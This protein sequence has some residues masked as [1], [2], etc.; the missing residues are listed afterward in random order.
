[1]S[2][3]PVVALARVLAL[4]L[5][6]SFGGVV[7]T[8]SPAAA[9]NDPHWDKQWAPPAIGAPQAW[10]TTTGAGVIIGIV[11]SGID[12]GHEDLAGKVAASTACIGTGGDAGRCSATP[13]AAQDVVGHGTHVAGIAAAT[14]D[15]GKGIAGIAP[16]ARLAVARVFQGDS[17]SLD[18]V[19]AG[20]R[21][22]VDN[23]ARVVNLSLGDSG[24]LLGGLLGGGGGSSLAPGIEY[25]WSKGAVT[26]LAAGNSNFLG[27]G[28]A[29]YGTVNAVVVGATGRN[30][31]PASYSSPTGNA[32][33]AVS[34]PGGDV[35]RGGTAG[36]VYS[37]FG[38]PGGTNEYAYLEGTSMAAPHVSG[39]LALLMSRPGMT[40]ATAVDIVLRTA[41]KSVRCGGNCAGRLDVAAAVAATGG[42][43][44]PPPPA[45]T[46]APV[47]PPPPARP[48]PAPATTAPTTP[49]PA[50]PAPPAVEVPPVEAVPEVASTEPEPAI[51][52]RP[53]PD[54][55]GQTALGAGL[56]DGDRDV[57]LPGAVSAAALL[58][59][60][61]AAAVTGRRRYGGHGGHGGAT[62]A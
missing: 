37:S 4:T 48:R 59:V 50:P 5:V 15:N 32:K 41:N 49:V 17:A 51:E 10:A 62:G 33:W 34:A 38:R 27:L 44:S 42:A 57:T 18:D 7:L 16:D 60:A 43:P 1:M 31:E 26:V 45:P 12:L 56:G 24:G 19:N 20:I 9:T 29:N 11:D 6:A 14:K 46:P 58:A 52:S 55:S 2:A 40:N 8:A 35:A 39:A 61:A 23:G 28:S 22:V 30:D 25:A 53:R 36:A 54:G 47:A 13:T 3:R 21:W